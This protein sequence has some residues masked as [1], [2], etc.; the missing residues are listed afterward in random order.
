MK[1]IRLNEFSL[2]GLL[3]CL[4][5]AAGCGP[6]A[7]TSAINTTMAESYRSLVTDNLNSSKPDP[8]AAIK[9][10]EGLQKRDPDNGFTLYLLATA[11]AHKS[12]W[13]SVTHNLEAGNRAAACVYYQRNGLPNR[14]TVC[15]AALRQLAQ[16]GATA[17]PGLPVE[18]SAA[19]LQALRGMAKRLAGAEPKTTLN[20]LMAV[21]IRSLADKALIERYTQ[22]GKKEEADRARQMEAADNA[23]KETVSK[24]VGL[25]LQE[26][27][28]TKIKTKLGITPAEY[29][30]L[31]KDEALTPE[32]RKKLEAMTKEMDAVT[33]PVVTRLLQSM[34]D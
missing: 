13:Q 24:E 34:P 30:A 22:A 21:Q 26:N 18:Q 28:E 23:W 33:D 2:A 1:T 10:L 17:A 3:F 11:Y 19:L 8:D 4:L 32:T 29:E 9:I 31:L 16:V 15:Y 25:L 5:F 14:E 27:Y 6:K 20:P 12:D 7:P